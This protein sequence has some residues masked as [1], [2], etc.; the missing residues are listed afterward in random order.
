MPVFDYTFTVNA[1]LSAV[2]AFHCD[3]SALRQLNPPF[4]IVQL[5]RVGPCV[6]LYRYFQQPGWYGA[7]GECCLGCQWDFSIRNNRYLFL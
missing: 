1:P 7:G 2:S 4:V 6:G 5:H 3:T